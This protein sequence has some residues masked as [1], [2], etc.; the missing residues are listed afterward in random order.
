MTKKLPNLAALTNELQGASLFF[1][2]HSPAP[3]PDTTSKAQETKAQTEQF[4][5]RTVYQNTEAK[6]ERPN[7]RTNDESNVATVERKK[8]RIKVRHTF[9]IFADQLFALQSL[10][11]AAV[12]SSKRKPT[13]GKMVQQAI[14]LY[15]AHHAKRRKKNR[16]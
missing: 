15:L 7:V 12:Q 2:P 13:L 1:T 16:A 4:P 8:N 9:D 3:K 6:N 5:P 10:Q 14:D 11:L